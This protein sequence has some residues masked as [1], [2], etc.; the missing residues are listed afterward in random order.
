MEEVTAVIIGDPH[1]KNDRLKE[2]QEMADRCI[3]LIEKK[4]PTFTVILGDTLHY[5]GTTKNAPFKMVYYFIERIV[6]VS[7][8]YILIGNHDYINQCQY[9]TDNHFFLPYR[10]WKGVTIVDRPIYVEHGDQSFV[11]CPYVPPMKF[12]KALN[13][14]LKNGQDWQMADCIFAH[15]E[16]KGCL[17]KSSKSTKGDSWDSE[18][19][20]VISGHIHDEQQVGENV[21]YTGTPIQH[22]FGEKPNKKVWFVSFG[23]SDDPPY[24]EVEKISLGMKEKQ[25]IKMDISEVEDFNLK[26]LE[27]WEVKLVLVCSSDQ[28]CVFRQSKTYKSLSKAGVK[29]TYEFDGADTKSVG[30]KTREEVSYLSVLKEVVRKKDVEVQNTYSRLLEEQLYGVVEF[31]SLESDS[32]SE[33]LENSKEDSKEDP[34]SFILEFLSSDSDLEGS[35]IDLD[36]EESDLEESDTEESEDTI[37]LEFGS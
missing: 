2:S 20:P 22:S 14:L 8:V 30:R 11:M 18:Y 34:K 15:Q 37:I 5:H 24:F 31:E 36:R 1:F 4:K 28:F 19:P 33:G 29:M 32:E 27:K 17:Y 16:F 9:L 7:P 23:K 26:I 12:E 3:Q 25:T 10:K 6:N 13:E 21:F 35:G